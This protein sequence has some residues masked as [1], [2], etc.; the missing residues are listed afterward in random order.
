M[1][2]ARVIVK[3]SA[4]PHETFHFENIVSSDV[5]FYDNI[6]WSR[7]GYADFNLTFAFDPIKKNTYPNDSVGKFSK[8]WHSLN[9][10]YMPSMSIELY[11]GISSDAIAKGYL[12]DWEENTEDYEVKFT[13]IDEL[14]DILDVQVS[15]NALIKSSEHIEAVKQPT[16]P[17]NPPE[18]GVPPIVPPPISYQS[19][20][21]EFLW[22]VINEY[23]NSIRGDA[24][25]LAKPMGFPPFSS[26]LGILVY[27]SN[28]IDQKLQT[29]SSGTF[30]IQFKLMKITNLERKEVLS[31]L[32]KWTRSKIVC[33]N[34][35]KFLS[36]TT[37][38]HITGY[39]KSVNA[40]N[41]TVEIQQDRLLESLILYKGTKLNNG[42]WSW[43][44]FHN[45]TNEVRNARNSWLSGQTRPRTE[46]HIWGYANQDYKGILQAGH[47]IKLASETF[48][49][50][51]ISYESETMH[52]I[53]S[54]EAVCIKPS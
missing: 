1:I 11:D 47:E 37:P 45:F 38:V 44:N 43:T 31:D 5:S 17:T 24:P 20:I 28:P 42:T 54:F 7:P 36:G 26:P 32:S 52:S 10:N 51:E 41:S 48:K 2:Y 30:L 16:G 15:R 19:T 35:I 18:G 40:D 29:Q 25:E 39:I 49:I 34:G 50:K 6:F 3:W 4:K 21:N 14:K 12:Y 23:W 53:K 33:Q 9:K 13:C 46:Y 8:W 27:L 22:S